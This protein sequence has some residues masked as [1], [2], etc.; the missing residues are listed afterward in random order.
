MGG[1]A[2][3]TYV[4]QR[5]EE[6]LL[7]ERGKQPQIVDAITLLRRSRSAAYEY[8]FVP[9]E[10]KELPSET[11]LEEL[12]AAISAKLRRPAGDSDIP[13]GYTYLGQFIFHDISFMG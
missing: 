6:F 4:I 2:R 9:E 12:G 8:V 10:Q 7:F 1:H 13:A 3:S 11:A 5:G